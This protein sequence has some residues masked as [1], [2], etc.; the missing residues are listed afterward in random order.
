MMTW[1]LAFFILA[2]IAALFGF[3]GVAAGA[4]GIGKVLFFAFVV[5]A[6][7]SVFVNTMRGRAL[8]R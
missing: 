3:G 2:V 4:A 7:V 5:L 8:A 6:V 1:A